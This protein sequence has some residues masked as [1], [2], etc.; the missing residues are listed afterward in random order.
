MLDCNPAKTP[1]EVRSVE[2]A[3]DIMRPR[4]DH[5]E[6]LCERGCPYKSVVGALI[7][8]ASNT[9]PDIAF[10]VSIL[11]RNC[12]DP[13]QRHWGGVKRVLRYLR[14]TLDV[15][16]YYKRVGGV[17]GSGV[18]TGYADAGYLSDPHKGRSQSGFVFIANGA[19]IFWRSSKQTLVATSSNHPELIALFEATKE[20]V[21]LRRVRSFI[22]SKIARNSD[23][24][25]IT[26]M[27]DNNAVI[28]QVK[29]GFIK[30][31]RTKHILPKFYYTSEADGVEVK[32]EKV[33][34]EDNIADIFTKSL[35]VQTHRKLAAQLG[36]RSLQ[37]L[38]GDRGE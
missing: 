5:E 7:Y 4:Q 18:I 34:S 6:G 30:S 24:G 15:G 19:A 26:I 38:S 11:A 10:A 35:P 22:N 1:M 23:A 37:E 27:E 2:P 28:S 25:L 32:I 31:D 8:I 9:R 12:A 36:L 13:C 16:L 3:Q 14:G 20:A 33:T 29:A 21:W 17:G